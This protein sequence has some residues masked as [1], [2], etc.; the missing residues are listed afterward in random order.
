[1][2]KIEVSSLQGCGCDTV[3]SSSSLYRAIPKK[4]SKK[5]L[6]TCRTFGEPE[7]RD[8]HSPHSKGTKSCKKPIL[9]CNNPQSLCMTSTRVCKPHAKTTCNSRARD[10]LP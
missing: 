2:A 6:Q 3:G 10:G 5:T 9:P 7:A 1:M 4:S 8:R